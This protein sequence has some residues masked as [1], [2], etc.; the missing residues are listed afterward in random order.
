MSLPNPKR[1]TNHMMLLI[2]NFHV[3]K[4]VAEESMGSCQK[5]ILRHLITF[6]VENCLYFVL[7]KHFQ[8]PCDPLIGNDN[9]KRLS[10]PIAKIIELIPGRD[11]EIRTVRLKTQHGTVIRPVQRI[12][13]LEVQAIS[14][15]DK[16]LKEESIS[17]KST[18]PEKVLNTND[19]IHRVDA[20]RRILE[21]KL[22]FTE[23][24][25]VQSDEQTCRYLTLKLHLAFG[26]KKNIEFLERQQMIFTSDKESIQILEH[27]K[28]AERKEL[29]TTLGEIALI[30]CPIPNC[31]FHTLEKIQ[32]VTG[33]TNL[34]TKNYE[35]VFEQNLNTKDK[36]N[37]KN[38]EGNKNPKTHKRTGQEDFKAPTKFARKCIEIPIEKVVCTSSNKFAVLD[39]E[40]IMDPPKPRIRPIMMRINKNYN[41]ILQEIYRTYPET[42]NKNTG[43]YIKIQLA[44]EEDHDNIKKLLIIKKADHYVNEEPKIIKIV[45]KGLPAPT[46]AADI[47]SDVK[48]KGIAVEK[49]AQLRRFATKASL[50]LFMV[51]V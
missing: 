1:N 4:E 29:D 26:L 30:S 34:G 18:K 51:E 12:F 23:V 47:E 44:S 50:P 10:W 17:V 9:K 19:A 46:N 49:V 11:G 41:L 48:E 21:L 6:N 8:H 28:E 39:N 14:N 3:M 13:P 20:A 36:N 40:E 43:N 24:D 35:K 22:F 38:K 15:S 45:L 42:V 25:F 5:N 2:I 31:P 33:V 37:I 16:E 32:S 27:K 7:S